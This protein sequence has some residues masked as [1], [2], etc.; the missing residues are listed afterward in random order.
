[1][2]PLRMPREDRVKTQPKIPLKT[3]RKREKEEEE[4]G[5]RKKKGRRGGGVTEKKERGV[6]SLLSI[7]IF[8]YVCTSNVPHRRHSG[9][10]KPRS[11]WL[12]F[13]S[14]CFRPLE[15]WLSHLK[16]WFWLFRDSEGGSGIMKARPG[17]TEACPGVSDSCSG[18]FSFWLAKALRRSQK[19]LYCMRLSS[20]SKSSL[21]VWSVR[22]IIRLSS[23]FEVAPLTFD[24][25]PSFF[26]LISLLNFCTI[27]LTRLFV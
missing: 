6:A 5:N 18:L 11:S 12:R 19:P 24:P 14:G 8:I 3:R 1:M 17:L 27:I 22:K 16:G 15:S 10:L 9:W 26:F 23:S 4:D 20:R 21:K 13:P 7:L 25:F 2:R